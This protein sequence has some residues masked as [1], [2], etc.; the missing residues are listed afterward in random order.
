VIKQHIDEVRWLTSAI[1]SDVDLAHQ[2]LWALPDLLRT[3][4]VSLRQRMRR[5]FACPK[6]PARGYIVACAIRPRSVNLNVSALPL[7]NLGDQYYN[8]LAMIH[9]ST[10]ISLN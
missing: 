9:N 5:P 3:G 1:T 4:T 8:K 10:I 2:L 6:R 7:L